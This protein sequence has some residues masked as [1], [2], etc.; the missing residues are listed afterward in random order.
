MLALLLASSLC[1]RSLA[2]ASVCVLMVAGGDIAEVGAIA[3][4]AAFAANDG[5]SEKLILSEI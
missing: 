3:A 4:V 5:G 2:F 1:F